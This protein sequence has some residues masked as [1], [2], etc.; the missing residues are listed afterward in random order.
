MAIRFGGNQLEAIRIG[1][2]KQN[3]LPMP[4]IKRQMSAKKKVWT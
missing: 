4:V 3:A 2:K 1:P